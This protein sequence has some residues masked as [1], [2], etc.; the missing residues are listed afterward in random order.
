MRPATRDDYPA[1]VALNAAAVQQTSAMDVDRLGLLAGLACYLKVAVERDEPAAFLLAL[2]EGASYDNDNYRWFSSRYGKFVYIDR[3]VVDSAHAGR[4]IGRQLY[5]DLF[6]YARSNGLRHV[7][8]EYNMEPPNPASA[9][10]H[11]SLNFREIGTQWV[12]QRSKRVSL[13][14]AEI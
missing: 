5:E 13:Q 4:G 11:Q 14:I 6:A 12:A 2:R 3:V 9:A 10:F 1:I 7:T 8:C